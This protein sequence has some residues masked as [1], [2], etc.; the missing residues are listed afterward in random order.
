[1]DTLTH[2][3]SGALLARATEPQSGTDTLSRRTRMAV[4]FWAAAFPDIDFVLR[5]ADPLTYLTTHRGVTHSVL[6]LPLWAA[7]LAVVFHLLYGRRYSWRAFAGVCAL[8]LGVHIAGDVITSFGTMILAPLSDW[9]A[10]L[11]A[12]FI[13]DPYFTGVIV[14]GLL[15]SWYWSGTRAPAIA[16]FA[17]L[18]GYVSFQAVLHDRALRVAD[19]YVAANRLEPAGTHALPQPFSPFH[20]L[21]V[22]EQPE[23]YHMSYV[24]LLRDRVPA[25]PT[26]AGFLRR[27]YDSYRPVDQASWHRVPRYGQSAAETELA[28]SVWEA[29]IFMRYRRFAM[30]PAVYRV[31]RFSE[32]V[33]VWFA[34][35]RFALVGRH[36]PFRYAGCGTAA[37]GDWTLYAVERDDDGAERLRALD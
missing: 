13:I 27:V 25:T 3:L 23:A 16:G 4:G 5:F 7:G 2:A 9:R 21:V 11:P 18:V 37:T 24:S 28:R 22:V 6:L 8:G 33:C 36:M 15:A 34:D 35:L 14:G 12:T 30:F 19:D 10:Q 26:D 29:P 20:W 31:D 1:M 17:I 32:R